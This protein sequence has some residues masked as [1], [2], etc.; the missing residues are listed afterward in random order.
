MHGMALHLGGMEYK[1][2]LG[3]RLISFPPFFKFLSSRILSFVLHNLSYCSLPFCLCKGKLVREIMA[4]RENS[5]VT[6]SLVL[7]NILYP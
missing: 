4:E 6:L 5:Q 7:L 1:T 2:L 3:F